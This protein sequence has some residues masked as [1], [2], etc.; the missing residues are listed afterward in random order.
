MTEAACRLDV[1]LW[2]ARFAKTRSLAAAL[3]ESGAVRVTHA[4]TQARIDR[5]GRAVRVGDGLTFVRDGRL[6]D[7]R[8]LSLGVR[9]GPAAEARALYQSLSS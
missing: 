8:I 5:P 4:G 9:R 7:L 3:V 6:H 2:R 1:W